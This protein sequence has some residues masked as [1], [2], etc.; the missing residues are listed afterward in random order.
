MSGSDHVRGGRVAGLARGGRV[1]GL[2]R[3][4][5]AAGL[6]RA[7]LP[8]RIDEGSPGT[9]WQTLLAMLEPAP[10]RLQRSLL[11]LPPMLLALAI[12]E[13]FRI[14][15]P[16]LGVFIVLFAA[17]E[18]QASTAASSLLF[19]VGITVASL[20]AVVILAASLSQPALRFGLMAA[21][22]FTTMFLSRA[23][24]LGMP[25]F[26]VGFFSVLETTAADSLDSLAAAPSGIA[27]TE[28][29]GPGAPSNLPNEEVLLHDV[30]WLGAVA[31]IAALSLMVVN[32]IAGR[33]PAVLLRA[34]LAKRLEAAARFCRG[35]DADAGALLALGREGTAPLLHLATLAEKTHR[36]VHRH[37]ANERLV[38]G[39]NRL[40]LLLV[41]WNDADPAGA[42][43]GALAPLARLCERLARRVRATGLAPHSLFEAP[44]ADASAAEVRLPGALPALVAE[45]RATLEAARRADEDR[46]AVRPGGGGGARPP[47]SFLLPD[48][49]SAANIRFALKVTLAVMTA[50]T[51]EHGLDW[52]GISTCVV[53][54]FF[55]AQGTLGESLHKMTLRLAGCLVGA[56]LG[57]GSIV[58]LM[59]SMTG[60][61]QLA[62]LVLSVGFVAAWVANGS[63][64]IAYAGIQLML[65][66]ALTTLQGYG[67]TLDMATARDRVVGILLGN[68]L[69]SMCLLFI[70]P[71]RVG[72]AV[73][74]DMAT[75]L[76]ALGGMMALGPEMLE[77][78]ELRR[79]EQALRDRFSG[80]VAHAGGTL[81][82]DRFEHPVGSGATI[83][84]EALLQLGRLVVPVSVI[85]TTD[86]PDAG[87]QADAPAQV[88]DA[89][90]EAADAF[91]RRM[92]A[93]FERAGAWMRTGE[94]GAALRATLPAAP[95]AAEGSGDAGL[96]ARVSLYAMLRHDVDRFLDA[97]LPAAT[98]TAER[99]GSPA[100]GG[101]LA[102]A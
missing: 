78:G 92:A 81:P 43:R 14:P 73:R 38:R 62:V 13:T 90:W 54:C 31:S 67:P 44:A 87:A 70:W 11:V 8:P 1:A 59:P 27:N 89:G 35:E 63:P 94:N 79:R 4:G 15:E 75:A 39:L 10:G 96:A 85:A 17:K 88:P 47:A 3:G 82:A 51:L 95:D 22:S 65:A 98:A 77:P 33:D 99:A 80:A 97:A 83:G 93:W 29:I 48:A 6:R 36:A 69:T 32:R 66:F 57:I 42:A 55:T 52:P 60:F 23:S 49:F 72:D 37:E 101:A 56:A 41:A 20:I 7:T 16:A 74:R 61:A 86:A 24:T 40:V 30:L 84:R 9:A 28:G 100:G 58:W 71:V 91:H 26:I 102:A 5:R 2:A 45:L 25:L 34:A 19:A 53:T 12:F 46:L 21:L 68:V 64:R 76:R 50:Y 18:D